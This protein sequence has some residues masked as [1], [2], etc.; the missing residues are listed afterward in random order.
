MCIALFVLAIIYRNVLLDNIEFGIASYG[1]LGLFVLVFLMDFT[2]QYLSLYFPIVSALLFGFNPFAVLLVSVIGSYAGSILAF[3]IGKVA[4]KRFIHDVVGRKDYKKVERGMN[5][6]GKWYVLA[7]AITFLPY[8]PLV[9]GALR[10]NRK[11]FYLFGVIPTTAMFFVLIAF[12][13]YI[14]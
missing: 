13:V 6:W 1:L 10:L 9:F 4:S 11:N 7:A 5:K 3:E 14:I 12:F 2:P 8:I